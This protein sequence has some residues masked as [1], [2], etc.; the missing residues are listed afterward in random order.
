MTTTTDQIAEAR[1]TLAALG[2]NRTAEAQSE[3]ATHRTAIA[4]AHTE[5]VAL[6][7]AKRNRAELATAVDAW[8][9]GIAADMS[10]DIDY[11]LARAAAGD[12]INPLEVRVGM[13]Q[14]VN[15][16][17]LL[18]QLLGPAAVATAIKARIVQ[19]LP[20]FGDTPARA[21]RVAE[22]D[23]ITHEASVAEEALIA[24]L[25]GLGVA[26]TRRFNAS[27]RAVLGL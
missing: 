1:A 4:N 26:V 20:D 21:V 11:H 14:S 6:A 15:L 7:D 22:L 24:E 27:P 3:L 2:A 16:A 9:A 25:E 12:A 23:T 19:A 18:V 13:G 17:P 5:R 8:A 10:R